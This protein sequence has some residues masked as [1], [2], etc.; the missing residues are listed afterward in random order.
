MTNYHY[1]MKGWIRTW[2]LLG[3]PDL[4]CGLTCLHHLFVSGECRFGPFILHSSPT[5]STSNT[6]EPTVHLQ[7]AQQTDGVWKVPLGMQP[8]ELCVTTLQIR[9]CNGRSQEIKLFCVMASG[10]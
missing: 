5:R 9:N 10:D 4:H 6:A 2:V 3:L 1:R 7:G 8:W